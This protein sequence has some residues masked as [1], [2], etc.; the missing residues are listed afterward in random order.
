MSSGKERGRDEARFQA[1]LERPRG[2]CNSAS[3]QAFSG[4]RDLVDVKDMAKKNHVQEREDVERA[5][6]E[7][8]FV[9]LDLNAR[10]QLR[11]LHCVSRCAEDRSFQLGTAVFE[12]RFKMFH[13]VVVCSKRPNQCKRSPLFSGTA[14]A[15][16][17]DHSGPASPLSHILERRIRGQAPD[18]PPS[19]SDRS[20]RRMIGKNQ[21]G[22]TAPVSQLLR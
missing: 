16:L 6:S 5:Q 11:L 9:W 7:A 10:H 21:S 12:N 22:D 3:L 15:W 4:N 2:F 19:P 18:A 1:G 20:P 14:K 17:T 8:C 13:I